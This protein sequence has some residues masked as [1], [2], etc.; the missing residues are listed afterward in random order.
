MT[1]PIEIF[2]VL[3]AVVETIQS[4]GG[5]ERFAIAYR[6]EH[7]LRAVVA[8]ACIVATGYPSRQ[9]AAAACSPGFALAA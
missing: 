6:N 5:R 7:S 4:S 9:E 2:T 1:Q 8:G 3:Y